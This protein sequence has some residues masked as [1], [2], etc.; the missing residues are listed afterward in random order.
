MLRPLLILISTIFLSSC[1]FL[2][3]DKEF[4]TGNYQVICGYTNE[5]Y[6]KAKADNP[7]N[8]EPDARCDHPL[9]HRSFLSL[10][11]KDH[12][13]L[14]IDDILLYGKYA[15]N[16]NKLEL[17]DAAKGKLSLD[18]IQVKKDFVQL[19][20]DFS[21]FNSAHLP[22]TERLYINFELDKTPIREQ[23]SKFDSGINLWRN[24]PTKAENDQEIKARALNFLDYSIAYFQ[25]ISNSGVH[26]DYKIDGVESP[27]TYAQNG[28]VL[29]EW[30]DVPVSWKELFYNEENA[31]VA[32]KYLL[33]G[34][35]YGQKE[36][37]SVK[38]L[39]LITFYLKNLRNS[40]STL[41]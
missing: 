31:L 29:K 6:L 40:L 34:F 17:I 39:L 23:P 32:Y 16:R 22:N 8:V 38:G 24:I 20:G 2:G 15:F 35:K 14:A 21:P 13:V 1:I 9:Y 25:H 5:V 37:Y 30:E 11:D 36:K 3:K 28:I 26:D 18:I 4:P 33:A 12:F 41:G 10:Q 19:K 27:I 7:L